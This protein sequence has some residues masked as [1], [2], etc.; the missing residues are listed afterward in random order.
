MVEAISGAGA[1]QMEML[2]R[3]QQEIIQ[4]L[5]VQQAAEQKLAAAAIRGNQGA[6]KA[7]SGALVDV[8][9]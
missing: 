2:I 6:Q 9:A 3:A 1:A 7:A 4:A 8:M 5:A